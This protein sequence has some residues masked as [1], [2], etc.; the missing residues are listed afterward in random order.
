M[1]NTRGAIE[2]RSDAIE[3]LSRVPLIDGHNDWANL[4]RGFYDNQ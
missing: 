4:V 3:L 2:T 1:E